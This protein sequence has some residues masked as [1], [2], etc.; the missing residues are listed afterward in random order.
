MFC[1]AIF[2]STSEGLSIAGFLAPEVQSASGLFNNIAISFCDPMG[3]FF[4]DF[5][6]TVFWSAMVVSILPCTNLTISAINELDVRCFFESLSAAAFL[7]NN[8]P[9]LASSVSPMTS[10]RNRLSFTCLQ[11]LYMIER[12]ALCAL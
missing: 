1:M 6:N 12:I 9:M 7:S 10:S 2:R 3:S 11:T 4:D 5:G 8:F